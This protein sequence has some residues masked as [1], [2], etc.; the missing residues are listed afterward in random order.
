MRQ[1]K[2][3]LTD[4]QWAKI[5]PLLSKEE[6]LLRRGRLRT[7]Y[8]EA[9]EGYF[10]SRG[11][12]RG[13]EVP[14]TLPSGSTCRRRLLPWEEEGLWLEIWRAFPSQ[15]DDKQI[16]DWYEA[17]IDGSFAPAKK[18]APESGKP[19]RAKERSGYWHSTVK[20]FHSEAISTLS[21]R[22]RSRL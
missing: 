18:G 1:P 20:V 5:E 22:L 2:P 13:G 6:P 14:P 16:L 10:G 17:F 12:E 4:E 8:R 7:H 15:L 9:W 3:M 11:P 19:R 21:R